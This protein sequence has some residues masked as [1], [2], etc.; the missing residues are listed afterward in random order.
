MNESYTIVILTFLILMADGTSIKT[1]KENA[2]CGKEECCVRGLC[3][4]FIRNGRRC[5][6]L[7]QILR[8]QCPC[9]VGSSCTLEVT[10]PMEEKMY[11]HNIKNL[12]NLKEMVEN[13]DI[14]HI[15]SNN[16]ED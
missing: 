16:I 5:N 9:A 13:R 15:E 10:F 12:N 11:C 4:P 6:P 1:C 3:M 2:M 7:A 14:K 8:L